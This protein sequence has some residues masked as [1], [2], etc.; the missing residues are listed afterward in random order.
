VAYDTVIDEVLNGKYQPDEQQLLAN[1]MSPISELWPE[2]PLNGY[3]HIYVSLPVVGSPIVN[4]GGECF[5]PLFA[6]ARDI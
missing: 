4:V 5:I 6:L 3:L 1:A 2:P